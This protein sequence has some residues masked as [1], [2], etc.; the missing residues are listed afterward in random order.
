M[1]FYAFLQLGLVL[2]FGLSGA[3][4]LRSP[5]LL[6]GTL[7]ALGFRKSFSQLGSWAV[8]LIELAAALLLLDRRTEA[9]GQF[10]IWALLL[11]FTWA[12]L[13]TWRKRKNVSCHC[14]GAW[15]PETLGKATAVR[16]M[17]LGITSFV[18]AWGRSSASESLYS[19]ASIGFAI[20]TWLGAALI[21]IM[22]QHLI[23]HI[24][25]HASTPYGGE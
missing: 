10:L 5:R 16:I 3:A 19:S 8:P 18:V 9:Y 17:L 13:L 21:Y 6:D 4:K 11:A 25:R 20:I 12:V 22:A 23:G 15:I 2:I 1:D 24:R 7:Q 14:F